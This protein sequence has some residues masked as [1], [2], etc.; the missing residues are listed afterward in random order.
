MEKATKEIEQSLTSLME[1]ETALSYKKKALL[2]MHSNSG[3][4]CIVVAIYE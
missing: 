4:N 3:S 1:S 2:E